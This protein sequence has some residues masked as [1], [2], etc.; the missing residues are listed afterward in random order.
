MKTIFQ[1]IGVV[2]PRGRSGFQD[3]DNQIFVPLS[4]AQKLLLGIN[5]V[6]FMRVKIDSAE[7]VPEAIEFVKIKLREQHNVTDPEN[8]DFSVRSTNQGIEAISAVTNGLKFF[9]AAIAAISLLVGGIGIM[10]IMLAAVEERTKE[11]GLRKAVG[12]RSSQITT[13]FM[14]ETIMITFI[15]GLIGVA[16]G[17]GIS[18]LVATIARQKGYNWDLVI[19]PS[20]ILLGCAVSIAIGLIFG[21]SPARRAASLNPIEALRHE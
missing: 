19:T 8:D 9:L 15:G 11:I 18:V 14:V 2:N 1:I 4:T 6:N 21:V 13:Q 5:Y 10:N 17:S 7:N 20:S 12:A 16:I 3:Q